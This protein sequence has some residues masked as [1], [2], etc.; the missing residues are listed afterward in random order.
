MPFAKND[1]FCH[2]LNLSLQ[3]ECGRMTESGEYLAGLPDGLRVRPLPS[4]LRLPTGLAGCFPSFMP[5]MFATPAMAAEEI[6]GHRYLD[7]THVRPLV[8]PPCQSVQGGVRE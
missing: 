5:D 2:R 1:P 4:M 3:T 7:K 6:A 8:L